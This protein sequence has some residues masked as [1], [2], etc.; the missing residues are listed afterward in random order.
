MYYLENKQYIERLE[1]KAQTYLPYR[2]CNLWLRNDSETERKLAEN[3]NKYCFRQLSA[4]LVS[5]K[6][7]KLQERAILK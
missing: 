7:L 5:F 6:V 4:A 1:D 3:S 2:S